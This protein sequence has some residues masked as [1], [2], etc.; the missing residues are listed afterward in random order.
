M[1]EDYG[2]Y[3]DFGYYLQHQENFRKNY[4]NKCVIIKDQQV[5]GVYNSYEEAWREAAE[6]FEEKEYHIQLCYSRE[7]HYRRKLAQ[8]QVNA[9][10]ALTCC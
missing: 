7:D 4:P 9:K 2:E 6:L 10:P 3:R 1:P 8:Q 5:V